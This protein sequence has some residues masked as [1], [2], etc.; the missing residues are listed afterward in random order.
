M[1]EAHDQKVDVTEQDQS[2][3]KI[4]PRRKRARNAGKPEAELRSVMKYLIGRNMSG[5]KFLKKHLKEYDLTDEQLVYALE[6]PLGIQLVPEPKSK[7]TAPYK[8]LAEKVRSVFGTT[9]DVKLRNVMKR[10]IGKCKSGAIFCRNYL[11]GLNLTDE[12]LINA[13]E[14]PLGIQ[15]VPEPRSKGHKSFKRLAKKVR[16]VLDAKDQS[17]VTQVPTFNILGSNF[18]QNLSMLVAE[19]LENQPQAQLRVK[20][21]QVTESVQALENQPQINQ[22]GNEF[23][24]EMKKMPKTKKRRKGM[25]SGDKLGTASNSIPLAKVRKPLGITQQSGAMDEVKKVP[26]SKKRRKGMPSGN[27]GTAS[28]SIPLAKIRRPFG[29]AQQS[30]ETNEVKKVPK[31]LKIEKRRKGMPS[32]DQSGSSGTASNSIP[33][34]KIRKPLGTTQQSEAIDDQN[35]DLEI[36]P[37]SIPL[38]LLENSLHPINFQEAD[39]LY[40]PQSN[41]GIQEMNELDQHHP[42]E[43]VEMEQFGLE[44]REEYRPDNSEKSGSEQSGS[45]ED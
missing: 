10:L 37:N 29:T 24:R 16:S 12:Q 13:L 31:A 38:R 9:D 21:Q 27:P 4:R 11:D 25:P 6:S 18:I 33:L 19:T 7:G 3:D 5:K 36:A 26:K 20:K 45:K 44:Q 32:V 42:L 2:S 14:S 43:T 15:F 30:E 41:N 17:T 28:N 1:A 40:L 35:Q 39:T 8:R 23:A 22:Q 34:A